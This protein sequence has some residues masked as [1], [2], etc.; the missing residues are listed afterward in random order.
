M[1]QK[2]RFT[3]K[4]MVYITASQKNKLKKIADKED[5]SIA[6]TIRQA[7]KAFLKSNKTNNP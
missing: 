6:N 4:V 7:I 1:P 2:K 5:V 3:D